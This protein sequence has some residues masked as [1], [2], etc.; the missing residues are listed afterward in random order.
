MACRRRALKTV[1]LALMLCATV[2]SVS[3][4]DESSL[5]L[6]MSEIQQ[7]VQTTES[8]LDKL[9]REFQILKD[10]RRKV[11][12]T[13]SE[14]TVNIETLNQRIQELAQQRDQLSIRVVEAE[15]NV[16][17]TR[18]NVRDRIRAMY[19]QSVLGDP[20]LPARIVG[21]RNRY[22]LSF[23]AR[24]IRVYDNRR[25]EQLAEALHSLQSAQRSLEEAY[26]AEQGARNL[27]V[28]TQQNV[29]IERSRLTTL[30]GEMR[31]KQLAAKRYLG[32]LQEKARIL[33]RLLQNLLQRDEVASEIGSPLSE[34][35]LPGTKTSSAR[36]A[37]RQQSADLRPDKGLFTRGIK[38]FRPIGGRV[39]Q[40]F[41]RTKV[42]S[43][44]DMVFSKGIEV[45]V[46]GDNTVYSIAPGRVVFAGA[47]PGYDQVVIIDHGA[48][49]HSLYGRMDRFNVQVGDML[50]GGSDI[51]T[52]AQQGARSGKHFYFE[53]RKN[54]KPIDPTRV[55]AF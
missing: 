49:S 25:F 6:R 26:G 4:G 24:K 13:I 51:G 36:Q 8:V 5:H 31:T 17:R 40:G 23:Y 3:W 1:G 27:L 10:K 19:Q 46:E 11:D 12:R 33:E 16:E 39:V 47:M 45:Q 21:Q 43:F 34:D 15:Q 54:G 20:P 55:V 9:K 32:R 50:P 48:R 18:G 52:I 28:R 14:L 2:R 35:S 22:E 41:G 53:I 44:S 7:E 42:R 30:L 38:V 29:E 37:G